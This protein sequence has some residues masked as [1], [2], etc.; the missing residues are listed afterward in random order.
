MTCCVVTET[1]A[2]EVMVGV[3]VGNRVAVSVGGAVLVAVGVA[4]ARGVGVTRTVAV[5][6]GVSGVNTA[7]SVGTPD[8]TVG[9]SEPGVST[10]GGVG[11]GAAHPR[12]P[13]SNPMTKTTTDTHRA[14]RIPLCA[15]SLGI[16]DIVMVMDYS[17][18]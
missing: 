5:G 18:E 15:V 1:V 8:T 3:A 13:T 9:N 16:D 14:H 10:G 17:Q 6:D 4:V 7:V 12:S 2:V 11:A